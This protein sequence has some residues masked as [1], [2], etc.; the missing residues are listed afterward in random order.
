M[1]TLDLPGADPSGA[2]PS[3]AR[4][5]RGGTWAR[6]LGWRALRL[7]VLLPV[8]AC[9]AFLLLKVS[10]I[11]PVRAYVG[12]RMTTV[13]PDQYARIA[14]K[15]GLDQPPLTQFARWAGNVAQGDLGTSMIFS[16]PVIDVIADRAAASLLLMAIAWTLSGLI[17]YGLGLL[18]GA[19]EGSWVDRAIKGYAF[20]LASAPTFWVAILLLVTFSVGLDWAPFCCAGPPG[21]AAADV[22]WAERLRHLALPAIALSV[23]GTA[24]VTLHTRDRMREVMRSDY[25]TLSAAQGLGR[26]AIAWR[27]GRRNAALPAITLQFAQLGELFGGSILAETVFS[28]PGLGQ[29]TVQAGTRGDAP[30]LLGIAMFAALFVFAGNTIADVLY[31]VVDPRL[32]RPGEVA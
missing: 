9:V 2:H 7:V 26:V 15:W 29:A 25:A 14:E 21:V 32:R 5:G 3:R 4:P 10:P 30:L 17:G 8:V 22:T 11:D 23:L 16:R 27:H 31:R 6:F 18:A 24:Q 19:L 28:Y 12:D 20:T 13:G 1:T